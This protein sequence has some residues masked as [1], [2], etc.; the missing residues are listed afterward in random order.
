[1]QAMEPQAG[2]AVA[3]PPENDELGAAKRPKRTY[4]AW[5]ELLART[6]KVDVLECPSCKGRMK[7]LA[8][9]TQSESIVRHL[10]A[11]GEPTDVPARSPSRGPP[12]W[13]S[14]VLRCKAFG[15]VA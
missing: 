8:I 4:R 2:A 3:Q 1:M 5:A 13:K 11:L 9:V 14:V 6:F 12:Y 10:A 15:E 7:L